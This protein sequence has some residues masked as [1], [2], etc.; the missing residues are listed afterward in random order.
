MG[1][2]E[3]D[4]A[5]PGAS[6]YKYNWTMEGVPGHQ[7]SEA[8]MPSHTHNYSRGTVSGKG[9]S[10]SSNCFSTYTTVTSVPTGGD[11]TH[12]HRNTNWRPQVAAVI[13]CTKKDYDV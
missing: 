13:I 9:S 7:L 1:G 3:Y 2:S 11:G 6:T 5:G 4:G 8:E 10:D 12:E